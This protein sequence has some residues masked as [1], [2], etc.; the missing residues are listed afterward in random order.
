MDD[1]ILIDEDPRGLYDPP[2]HRLMLMID[3]MIRDY[4]DDI[5]CY[6]VQEDIS[7][8]EVDSIISQ[9]VNMRILDKILRQRLSYEAR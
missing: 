5:L 8:R 9:E 6:A 1:S 3:R 4:L 2:A 7:L